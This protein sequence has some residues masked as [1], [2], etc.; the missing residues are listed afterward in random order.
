MLEGGEEG[1][2]RRASGR[3]VGEMERKRERERWREGR[4]E[5]FVI[6]SPFHLLPCHAS[7]RGGKYT[8]MSEG[9]RGKRM[10]EVAGW[11]K[12]IEEGKRWTGV[13]RRQRKAR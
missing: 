6:C 7:C 13:R 2:L 3:T 8:L 11:N 1:W 10:S 4:R 12:Q 5:R 9:D